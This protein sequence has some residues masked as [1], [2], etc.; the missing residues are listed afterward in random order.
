MFF[1]VVPHHVFHSLLLRLLLLLL[2]L[3]QLINQIQIE[4]VFRIHMPGQI[5]QKR[6][7]RER[8]PNTTITVV[9]IIKQQQKHKTKIAGLVIH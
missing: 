5:N 1:V 7:H 9:K 6:E 2:L 3:L 8:K 4:I